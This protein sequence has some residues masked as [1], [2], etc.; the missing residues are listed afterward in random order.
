MY[1]I[2]FLE[3]ILNPI[4]EIFEFIKNFVLSN[5]KNCRKIQVTRKL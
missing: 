1:N 2:T 4:R 5:W 3:F